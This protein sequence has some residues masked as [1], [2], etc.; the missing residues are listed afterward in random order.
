MAIKMRLQ[1]VIVDKIMEKDTKGGCEKKL[2]LNYIRFFVG[3]NA[4]SLRNEKEGPGISV[5]LLN[6]SL[7]DQW[8][9]FK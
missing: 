8:Y 9:E 2:Q 3:E 5:K 4:K 1:R 6:L 7:T